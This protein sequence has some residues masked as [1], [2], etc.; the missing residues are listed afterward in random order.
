MFVVIA[1]IFV[2]ESS[3][4]FQ[5]IE[6]EENINATQKSTLSDSNVNCELLDY[7][8]F[9][10][11]Y[12]S[13]LPPITELGVESEFSIRFGALAVRKYHSLK[14]HVSSDT[15]GSLSVRIPTR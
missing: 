9:V 5:F 10:E 7:R 13:G 8:F 15:L 4:T 11:K 6:Y 3:L 12:G 2:E 14:I 1:S